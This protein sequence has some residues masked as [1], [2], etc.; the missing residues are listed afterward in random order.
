ERVLLFQAA[1]RIGVQVADVEVR[2]SILAMKEFQTKGRFNEGLY[3]R[4]LNLNRLTP[5]AFENQKRSELILTKLSALVAGSGQVTPQEVDQALKQELTT[6]KAA[7]KV[8]KTESFLDKIKATATEVE[9]YYQG[10]RNK[11]LI[12]AQVELYY[13]SFLANDFRDEVDV[14]DKDVELAY[15]MERNRYSRPEQVHARHILVRLPD[16]PAEAEIK[17]ARAKAEKILALAKKPGADFA[18][19][20]KEHSQGPTAP[21]GGDLGFFQRG[22]MVP[23]FEKLAF[24]LKKGQVGLVKTRFGFHVVK[25]EDHQESHV[26]P[27]EEVRSEIKERLSERQA[28]ELAKAAAE[29]ALDLAAQNIEPKQL[30]AKLKKTLMDTPKVPVSGQVPGL[31]GLKGLAEALEGLKEGQVLPVLGFDDGSILAFVK[32]RIPAAPRPLAEVEEEVRLAVRQQKAAQAARQAAA[33]L[34]KELPKG[35]DAAAALLKK[36]G[37]KESGWLKPQGDVK[38]LASSEALVQALFMRP[39]SAPLLAEPIAVGEDFT[40]AAVKERKP[41]TP[42]EIKSQRAEF[43]ARLIA[44]KRR[45]LLDR[46]RQD[47]RASADVQVLAAGL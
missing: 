32:K 14:I 21:N 8:F 46:F 30:A 24:G 19:L 12:P 38:E 20:A 34:L 26:T 37:A 16:N 35:T 2:Q 33:E 31:K 18:A 15:E 9:A 25:V 27:L 4:L 36:S 11:Y 47:L 6:L 5:E 10:N 7:Y 45:L 22:Q 1:Y 17:A 29:R 23:E 42:E 13:L 40:A 41:P 39:D 44:A 43:K 3:R 28:R